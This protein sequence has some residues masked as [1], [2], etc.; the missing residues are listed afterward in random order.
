MGEVYLE[1]G[2]VA[3]CCLSL[4]E[5]SAPMLHLN[6]KTRSPAHASAA[7]PRLIDRPARL[8]KRRIS[9]NQ[10]SR[11][12]SLAMSKCKVLMHH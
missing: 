11:R 12:L 5:S 8:P 3:L 10:K 2:S 9:A 7:R 6:I 1:W 4:R